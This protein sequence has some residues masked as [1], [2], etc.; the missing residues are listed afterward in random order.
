MFRSCL[1]LGA[2]VNSCGGVRGG[3]R[4]YLDADSTLARTRPGGSILRQLRLILPAVSLAAVLFHIARAAI[5][6]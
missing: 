4:G 6:T 3:V 5:Y 1:D 2:D